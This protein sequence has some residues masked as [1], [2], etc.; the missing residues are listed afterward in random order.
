V[1]FRSSLT[2]IGG[3]IPLMFET[4]LQAQFLLPMA[5]T[6]VFGLALATLLVLF[7]VPTFLGIGND[8]ARILS[9]LYGSDNNRVKPMQ[10]AE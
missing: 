6:M 9:A 1:L 8:I 3:L 4:S 10:P 2:T 7:L 5:T